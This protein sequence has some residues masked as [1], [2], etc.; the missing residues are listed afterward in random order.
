MKDKEFG[1]VKNDILKKDLRQ[2][3][4]ILPFFDLLPH[5]SNLH[6][7]EKIALLHINLR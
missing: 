2:K 1:I 3:E 7:T 6:I 4:K 5:N